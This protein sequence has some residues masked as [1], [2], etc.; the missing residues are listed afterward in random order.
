MRPLS[1]K[2]L[3]KTFRFCFCVP[4]RRDSNINTL[5]PLCPFRPI[6]TVVAFPKMK[7]IP[8]MTPGI[9]IRP[10]SLKMLAKTFRFFV[11]YRRGFKYQHT[12]PFGTQ[13]RNVLASI[14]RLKG[15]MEM[16]DIIAGICFILG[17]SD[18]C[19]DTWQQKQSGFLQSA[20]SWSIC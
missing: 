19:T 4:C 12:R 14:L 3:A 2:M 16:R 7:Q 13:K 6:R 5:I 8:V 10:L 1:L 18:S 15:R 11:P 20:F 9:S 17:E